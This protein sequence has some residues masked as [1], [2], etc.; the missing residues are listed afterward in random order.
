MS[1][2][3]YQ[4]VSFWGSFG[5]LCL[6]KLSTLYKLSKYCF[7]IF[8]NMS[9]FFFFFKIILFSY[10]SFDH[11]GPSL[12][13]GLFS[14]CG[15]WGCSL[16]WLLLLWSTFLGHK[17]FS[18]CGLGLSS[19]GSWILEHRLSR[20]GP[21]ASLFCRMWDFLHQGSNLHLLLWQVILYHRATREAVLSLL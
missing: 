20:C 16:K 19:Y 13:L 18:S 1:N 12:L 7:L 10:F 15:V 14:S 3:K 21:R 6:R 9:S 4:V 2:I 5:K 11:S 17:G 8:F